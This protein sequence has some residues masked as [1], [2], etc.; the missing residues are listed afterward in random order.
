MVTAE[1]VAEYLGVAAGTD[2]SAL[3]SAAEALISREIG[4]ATVPAEVIDNATL[5]LTG[6]LHLRAS[7]PGGVV[8]YAGGDTVVRVT[9][10]PLVSIRPLLAPWVVPF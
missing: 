4:T 2:V 7:N 5:S 3:L 9:R 1:Q 10:D 8:S 6:E